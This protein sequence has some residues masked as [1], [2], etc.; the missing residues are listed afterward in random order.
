MCRCDS[1]CKLYIYPYGIQPRDIQSINDTKQY[2]FGYIEGL[3]QDQIAHGIQ[4]SE[5]V[6]AVSKSCNQELKM[7]ILRENYNRCDDKLFIA[8]SCTLKLLKR[9][10]SEKV[11]NEGIV[12]CNVDIKFELKHFFFNNLIKSL[13][14]IQTAII[15][16]IMPSCDEFKEISI[17]NANCNSELHSLERFNISLDNT[18]KN[19]LLKI[20]A[21]DSESPPLLIS[22][23]FGTGKT[24]LLAVAAYCLV[25]KGVATNTPTRVLICAHHLPT[26]DSLFE[27]YF[28]PISKDHR[29]EDFEMIRLIT[30]DT[31]KRPPHDLAHCYKNS[32]EILKV[33]EKSKPPFIIVASTFGLSLSLEPVFGSKYFTHIFLDEGSQSREPEA[34]SSLTLASP[35]TK[36]VIAGDWNQVSAYN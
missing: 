24:R 15:G 16:R 7:T 34:I 31:V 14:N 23:A 36:I 1:N 21:C 28:G 27:N 10:F 26:L 4:A 9:L 32:K 6:F 5:A 12:L 2:R 19:G 18:Q 13:N 35:N 17:S 8:F 22:G 25:K 11:T 3:S 29:E 20:M 30:R 33:Y